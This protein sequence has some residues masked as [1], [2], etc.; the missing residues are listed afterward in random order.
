MADD[1]AISVGTPDR[2]LSAQIRQIFNNNIINDLEPS[3]IGAVASDTTGITGAS[4]INN[5]ISLT[6]A[7]YDALSPKDANTLYVIV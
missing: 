5:I 7:N 4:S 6:Q 3:D 2:V 1:F